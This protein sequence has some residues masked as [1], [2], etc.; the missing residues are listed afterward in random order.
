MTARTTEYVDP[1]IEVLRDG[2]APTLE[3][4]KE[5]FRGAP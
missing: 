2:R 3:Q 5:K 1:A 4:A